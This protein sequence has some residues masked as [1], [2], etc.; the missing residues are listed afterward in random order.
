MKFTIVGTG[1][2]GGTI[3]AYL[4][5]AGNDVTFIA[6]GKHLEAI[7]EKGLTVH[8][9]HRGDILIRPAQAASMDDCHGM[10]PDVMFVCVKYYSLED[11]IAFAKRTAGPDTLIIPI[12]NV[13]GTGEVMQQQLPGLTCLD[14]CM[15]IVAK[16]QE[17]GVIVQPNEMLRIIYGFRTGQDERLRS[18]AE[19]LEKVLRAADI[20]G[21]FSEHIHRDAMQKFA[22]IS[23]M[24]AAG[25][26]FD[27]VSEDFQKEG[28]VRD[29]FVGLVRE[30][31]AVGAAMGLSFEKDLVTTGLKLVDSFQPGFRTSMQRDVLAKGPSEFDG[32][33]TRMVELGK[34]YQVPVPLYTKISAWGKEHHLSLADGCMD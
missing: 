29:M 33:V 26:Y 24:G 30:V 17:P 18:K 31:A 20:R 16:I 11:A 19:E 15:Y 12:L 22:F 32:L 4:A 13:F 1:G 8:T 21:H 23:P 25:L 14:G 28:P 3:G 2:T 7:R 34:R 10:P 6:R 27:A 9:E 5:Q